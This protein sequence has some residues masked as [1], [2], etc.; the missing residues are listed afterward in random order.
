[1][2]LIFFVFFS[3]ISV[4]T[5]AYVVLAKKPLHSAIAFVG[6]LLSLAGMY[7]VLNAHFLAVIQFLV[8][9]VAVMALFFLVIQRLGI[10]G[11][12]SPESQV[13]TFKGIAVIL[14]AWITALHFSRTFL[15]AKAATPGP[16]TVVNNHTID[17][18]WGGAESVGQLLLTEY[19]LPFEIV[20]V[21]LLTATVGA[22]FITRRGVES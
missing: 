20:S 11:D 4:I 1:M 22:L 17:P 14:V 8:A 19:A 5:A 21:L 3:G 9:T 6:T 13:N 18:E 2:E 16:S 15:D 10:Q 7:V 12:A